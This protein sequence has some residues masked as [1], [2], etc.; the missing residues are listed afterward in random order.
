VLQNYAR[1]NNKA[2]IFA[3]GCIVYEIVT[4][5]KRFESDW[6]I[7]EYSLEVCIKMKWPYSHGGSVLESIGLF[8]SSMLQKDPLKR[9]NAMR[10][11]ANLLSI[12]NRL[13]TCRRSG[14]EMGSDDVQVN[15]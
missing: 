6:A 14:T 9:P 15:G 3:L 4:G 10:L 2:D 13:G 12:R 11:R 7:F 8:V 5:E 1:Y